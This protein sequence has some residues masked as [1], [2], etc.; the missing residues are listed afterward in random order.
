MITDELLEYLTK[1]RTKT[2][3]GQKAVGFDCLIEAKHGD[4]KQLSYLQTMDSRPF[5]YLIRVDSSL[6]LD[7]DYNEILPED[8]ECYFDEMLMRMIE[9]EHDNIDRYEETE[10]GIYTCDQDK[11]EGIEPFEY[12]WPMFSLGAGH[13]YG[14]I[15]VEYCNRQMELEKLV[16]T[17]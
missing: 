5:H 8:S 6:D 12:K 10:C 9:E 4:G 1:E 15:D 7:K 3:W 14:A 2:M 17:E 16:T 11:E 13:S